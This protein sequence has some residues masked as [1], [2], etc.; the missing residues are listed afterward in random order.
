MK[1][2]YLK[3]FLKEHDNFYWPEYFRYV[4]WKVFPGVFIVFYLDDPEIEKGRREIRL[5]IWD[6]TRRGDIDHPDYKLQ[7]GYAVHHPQFHGWWYYY[8]DEVS[9]E[10]RL[11]EMLSSHRS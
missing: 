9:L 8:L 2:K 1:Y 7:V 6:L 11:R 3:K 4:L 10:K 5:E